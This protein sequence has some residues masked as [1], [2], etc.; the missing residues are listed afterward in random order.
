M[1][2]TDA[3]YI[4]GD[5]A[6]TIPKPKFYAVIRLSCLCVSLL[7]IDDMSRNIPVHKSIRN[8]AGATSAME[9]PDSF[10]SHGISRSVSP[11]ARYS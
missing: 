10:Q 8:S 3:S 5:L 4:G 2:V 6:A 7:I 9:R 1:Y 11:G